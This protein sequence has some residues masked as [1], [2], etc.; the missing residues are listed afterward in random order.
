METSRAKWTCCASLAKLAEEAVTEE[1]K[2]W[3]VAITQWMWD[4]GHKRVI[5]SKHCIVRWQ[6]VA[7]YDLEAL[8][9]PVN[10]TVWLGIIILTWDKYPLISRLRLPVIAFQR[11]PS[12]PVIPRNNFR[13]LE[14][15][16]LHLTEL[17]FSLLISC[18][19][20]SQTV[21]KLYKERTQVST[22]SASHCFS[23]HNGLLWIRLIERPLQNMNLSSPVG[24]TGDGYYMK[25]W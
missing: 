20:H 25:L 8:L 17:R 14:T 2:E 21:Q 3:E 22:I 7:Q 13:F 18:W 12:T 16:G 15:G 19:R 9:W 24:Q 6:M 5:E 4:Y 10:H 23:G 11:F 1:R